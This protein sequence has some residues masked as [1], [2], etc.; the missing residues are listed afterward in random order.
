MAAKKKATARKKSARPAK[1]PPAPKSLEERAAH[2][3]IQQGLKT[4]GKTISELQKGMKSAEREIEADARRR[5]AALRKE[6]REQLDAIN[7]KGR[8]IAGSLRK[9]SAAAET[10]WDDLKR[11][12]EVLIAEARSAA[13]TFASRIRDVI[14]R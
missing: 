14:T 10:S 7:A 13:V 12:A 8:D 4:L 9:A 5:I 3:E 6:G 1:K 11:S 2:F